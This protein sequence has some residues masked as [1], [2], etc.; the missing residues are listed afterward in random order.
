MGKKLYAIIIAVFL[1]SIQ[2]MT[3]AEGTIECTSHVD[4]R[5]V[6]ITGKIS[7]VTE[8]KMV[9]LL[10]GDID[11]IIYIAQKTTAD[12]GSFSFE[13]TLPKRLAYGQYN[14]KVGANGDIATYNGIII[15]SEPVISTE[16]MFVNADV[17]ISINNFIPK[18]EG[19]LYCL[20]GKSVTFNIMNTTDQSVI[21]SDVITVLDNVYELS[22]SLPSLLYKKNYTVSLSCTDGEATL[23]SMNIEL[24]SSTVLVSLSGTAETADNVR[25]NAQLQSVNTGLVDK[26][27]TF[28]GRKSISTTIP[29]VV[30]S[31]S[32]KLSAQGYET[33]K[34]TV[35]KPAPEGS[36]PAA[37]DSCI[38]SGDT[39]GSCAYYRYF[40]KYNGVYYFELND[41]LSVDIYKNG[42]R[43]AIGAEQY[44]MNTKDTYLIC[45]NPEYSTAY[46]L[47]IKNPIT[48]NKLFRTMFNNKMYYADA[49][50]SGMMF[51]DGIIA[52]PLKSLWISAG[53][54]ALYFASEDR[55]YKY[56][57]G[58]ST[59][60]LDNVS[61]WYMTYND[62]YVYFA[63]WKNSGRLCRYN[64]S[65]TEDIEIICY[66]SCSDIRVTDTEIF[67]TDN[68]KADASCSILKTDLE[69]EDLQ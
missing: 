20:A 26:S 24:S 51:A 1:L 38:L 3:Y 27:T 62:G 6:T 34:E 44:E 54:E 2:V 48:G 45:I 15:Y 7:G 11:N 67:Y 4:E 17:N 63:D 32:Y 40:P 16:K 69:Q 18:I 10:V 59:V 23:V 53:E 65:G 42:I 35:S 28:T 66:D 64:V 43:T 47:T 31:T 9:S 56:C 21:A 22:Y 30:A 49:E 52:A 46:T 61:P 5:N 29:N 14:Y 8:S 55:I 39:G 12:D 41:G 13:F 33:I 50:N 19:T 68:T 60:L 37:E 36:Y 25:I 57:D 58:K